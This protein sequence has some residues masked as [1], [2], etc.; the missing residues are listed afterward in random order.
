MRF[1]VSFFIISKMILLVGPS[2]SGKTEIAKCLAS[3]FG[4]KKAITHTSRPPRK[5]E[6]Q[7]V[8]YHFVSKEEFLS[9]KEKG[10]FV[11]TT[12]YNGNY[13]GCSKQEI[14]DDRCVVV[15]PNGLASFL[16]LKDPRIVVFSLSANE[17]TRYERMKGRGDEEEKIK[18]R[19]ENDRLAFAEEKLKEAHFCIDTEERTVLELAIEIIKLY[20]SKLKEI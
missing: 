1:I 16:A 18:E 11:E 2:A 8:D 7:D 3:S 10:C 17:T 9:L 12:S 20:K 19:I 4:I 6:T 13:Y 5:G 15:D 14:Q